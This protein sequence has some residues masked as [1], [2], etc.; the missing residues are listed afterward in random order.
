VYHHVAALSVAAT[1]ALTLGA[2]FRSRASKDD[3]AGYKGELG[4]PAASTD[5]YSSQSEP[6]AQSEPPMAFF[7]IKWRYS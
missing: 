5:P 3:S 2:A 6:A 4:W 1:A 7:A